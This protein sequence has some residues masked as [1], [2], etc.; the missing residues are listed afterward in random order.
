MSPLCA[1]S[2]V[3]IQTCARRAPVA[4]ALGMGNKLKVN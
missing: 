4:Q 2:S 3:T 1:A